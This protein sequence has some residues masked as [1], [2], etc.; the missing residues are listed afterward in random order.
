M[1]KRYERW[2]HEQDFEWHL[3]EK[4]KKKNPMNFN[5]SIRKFVP[6]EQKKKSSYA[7][8]KLP[9][10]SMFKRLFYPRNYQLNF[11]SDHDFIRFSGKKNFWVKKH[12]SRKEGP[13]ETIRVPS[14]PLTSA[15]MVPISNSN[16][17]SI[18]GSV[19]PSGP[20]SSGPAPSGPSAPD[21]NLVLV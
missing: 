9:Q 7:D 16:S 8:V 13:Q 11:C 18:L 6:A 10:H 21:F 5:P 1:A 2:C 3:V 4:R 15:N 19:A 17:K 12:I 20:V 14:P